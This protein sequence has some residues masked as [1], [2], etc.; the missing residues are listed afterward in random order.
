L[1]FRV[2]T[3]GI[4]TGA[5]VFGGGGGGGGARKGIVFASE[6]EG[7]IADPVPRRKD[8]DGAGGRAT[9]GRR[10]GTES[11]GKTAAA[12]EATLWGAA[13]EAAL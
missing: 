11:D 3:V 1:R 4:A 7:E 8:R 5:S 2:D 12:A 13:D 10:R 6:A 9:E